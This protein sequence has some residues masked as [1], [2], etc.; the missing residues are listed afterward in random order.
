MRKKCVLSMVLVM[1]LSTVIVFAG[2]QAD[3]AP[4]AERTP[5]VIVAI[6]ADPADLAP[7]VG[8]SYGRI[9]V[10]HTMYEYLFDLAEPGKPLV[11]Y[12]AKSY[13]KV[14]DKT[15]EV[16]LF[17]TVYDS[18]GNHITAGD[19]A[20]SYQTAMTMG[21]LRPLGDI[22]SVRA[23]GE[24]TVEFVLKK[25]PSMGDLEK[26]L[27]EAPIVSKTA[28]EGS[29]DK[30][31]TKPITTSP[32]VLTSYIPGSSLTFERRADYWQ[33]DLTQGPKYNQA[34]IQRIVMQVIS[35][36]AQHAIALETKSADISG[37]INSADVP[38]FRN[39]A[40]YSLF[41]FQDN[42]SQALIYN[43]STGSPFTNK[44]LRQAIAYALDTKAMCAAVAPGASSP[45]YTIG[46]SNFGGYLKKWESENYYDFDLTKAQALFAK[47]GQKTGL[48][49]RMLVQNDPRYSLMSQIIKNQL[50]KIG[51][52]VEIKQ[53]EPTVFNELKPN[54]SEWDLMIDAA[55]GGDYIFSP[56]QL[57]YDQNRNKGA[58]WGF[59]KDDTLQ[60]KLNEAAQQFTAESIDAFHQ[61]QK[62]QLYAYGLLSF[63]GI[64][65]AREGITNVVLDNRRQ[66]VPGACSYVEGF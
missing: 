48:K 7:F 53:V 47:S 33:K 41:T 63:H 27:T 30:F 43:G 62:E 59:F 57:M 50:S 28:Y 36:P 44:D 35:E 55:A 58:T 39:K 21:Y 60:A 49:V 45:L 13:K 1:L 40:G 38:N 24:Y 25:E 15:Y 23:T 37:N 65:V 10:L 3:K 19:A 56:A 22:Q 64:V 8:M 16:T 29:S 5:Q 54:A 18:A 32:Y 6:G 12:I 26:V 9:Q 20:W 51:I 4:Q 14:G 17:E 61:Y 42:L 34:N 66:I 52:E 2:G 31:A 46:N 11:P